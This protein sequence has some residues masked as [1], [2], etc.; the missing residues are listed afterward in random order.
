MIEVNKRCYMD[1]NT[2][3]LAPKAD[4]LRNTINDI[5]TMLLND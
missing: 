2:M 3:R 1:E 5:Y 4:K